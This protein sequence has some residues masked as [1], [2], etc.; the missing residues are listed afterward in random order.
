MLACLP[1]AKQS[2]ACRAQLI[3]PNRAKRSR[4]ACSDGGLGCVLVA[5]L[6]VVPSLVPLV[7]L[8][9]YYWLALRVSNVVSICVLFYT[10]YQWG[11]YSGSDPLKIGLLLAAIGLVLAGIAISL[12]G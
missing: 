10:G 6:S 8:R 9:D 7:L 2:S 5:V 12:G 4:R 11:K 3:A 1:R